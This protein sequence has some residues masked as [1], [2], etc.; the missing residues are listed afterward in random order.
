MSWTAPLE[1]DLIDQGGNDVNRRS[2]QWR[3][4]EPNIDFGLDMES[5]LTPIKRILTM[6]ETCSEQGIVK[7]VPKG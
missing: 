1:V 4:F 3:I 2:V 7:T 5:S 6:Q